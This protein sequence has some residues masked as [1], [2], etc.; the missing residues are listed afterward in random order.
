[1]NRIEVKDSSIPQVSKPTANH[2]HRSNP[3][4]SVCGNG[5]LV[6]RDIEQPMPLVLLDLEPHHYKHNF[7]RAPKCH[8][9]IRRT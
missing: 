8:R 6:R 9:S 1:M 3:L 5:S 2:L 4:Q 7:D